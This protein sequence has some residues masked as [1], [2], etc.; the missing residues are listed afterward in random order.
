MKCE[1]KEEKI[2]TVSHFVKEIDKKS[3]MFVQTKDK[4]IIAEGLSEK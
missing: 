2:K 4:Y 3:V 1:V